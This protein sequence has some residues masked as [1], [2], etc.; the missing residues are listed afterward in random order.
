MYVCRRMDGWMNGSSSRGGA[1]HSAQGM[2]SFPLTSFLFFCSLVAED[3][4]H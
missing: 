1:I 3:N 4:T 2:D